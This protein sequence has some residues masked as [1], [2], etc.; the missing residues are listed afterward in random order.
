MRMESSSQKMGK[1]KARVRK[2]NGV[3]TKIGQLRRFVHKN[4]TFLWTCLRCE[5]ICTYYCLLTVG[6]HNYEVAISYSLNRISVRRQ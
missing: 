5:S 2:R 1:S 3:E 6:I 4:D